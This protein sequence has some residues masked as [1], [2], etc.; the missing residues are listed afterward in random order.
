MFIEMWNTRPIEDALSAELQQVKEENKKLREALEQIASF[1]GGTEFLKRMVHGVQ[2]KR[3]R[4][5]NDK[6]LWK[7]R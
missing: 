4:H 5:C 7:F 3:G 6:N 2:A 1:G